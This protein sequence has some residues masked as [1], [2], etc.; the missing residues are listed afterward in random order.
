VAVFAVWEPILPTDWSRPGASV[1]QRL[2]DHRVRQFWDANHMVAA[3]L[4]KAEEA[5]QL[6]PKCCER[7]GVP[8]DLTAAYA[9]GTEWRETLPPPVLFDGPVVRTSPELDSVI[10]K[11]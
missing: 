2:K 5:G 10:A 6:H 9:A 8:W 1:L 4:K 3:V 11:N 7:K